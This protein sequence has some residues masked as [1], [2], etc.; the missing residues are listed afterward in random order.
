M[1]FGTLDLEPKPG[2]YD[3]VRAYS[4]SSSSGETNVSREETYKLA[5]SLGLPSDAQIISGVDVREVGVLPP[6]NASTADFA[7]VCSKTFRAPEAERD[8]LKLDRGAVASACEQHLFNVSFLSLN[9]LVF[10]LLLSAEL[11]IYFAFCF[12]GPD[13]EP[14]PREAW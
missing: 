2:D 8:L 14:Y 9:F 1:G 12:A 3:R 5:R 10:R 7:E 11:L 6:T 4:G 13:P